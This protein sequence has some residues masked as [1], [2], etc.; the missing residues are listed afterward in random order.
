MGI[1]P[2]SDGERPGTQLGKEYNR[3]LQGSSELCCSAPQKVGDDA[4][5]A[6]RWPLLPGSQRWRS[7]QCRVPKPPQPR[8]GCRSEHRTSGNSTAGSSADSAH[9]PCAAT[10]GAVTASVTTAR[11][12]TAED[13]A[14]ELLIDNTAADTLAARTPSY[15][16]YHTHSTHTMRTRPATRQFWQWRRWK[17]CT[18][19]SHCRPAWKW[20]RPAC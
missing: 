4:V 8:S 17:R 10:G 19:G 12:D 20:R 9:A 6:L 2:R 13:V 18:R 15:G 5:R 1:A 14:G 7:H 16:A 3:A 11:Q